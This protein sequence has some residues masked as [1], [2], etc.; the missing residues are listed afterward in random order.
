MFIADYL[1]DFGSNLV[2][3][4]TA[5][6]VNKNATRKYVVIVIVVVVVVVGS[7]MLLISGVQGS[8]MFLVSGAEWSLELNGLCNWC[9]AICV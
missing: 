4:L 1:Q 2:P 5:L 7:L 8:L 3:A 9:F 6:D